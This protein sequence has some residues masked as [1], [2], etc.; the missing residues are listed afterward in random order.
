MKMKFKILDRKNEN[1]SVCYLCKLPLREY[2]SNLPQTYKEFEVQRGIV[3]NKYLDRLAESIAEKKHIPAIVLVSDE[4]NISDDESYLEVRDFDILDGLQRTHRFKV[5]YDSLLL[6][7]STYV[8]GNFTSISKFSRKYSSELKRIDSSSKLLRILEKY[9]P[10]SLADPLDFFDG[11]DIWVEVWTGLEKKDQ[12]KKMLL[13]NAGHKSVNIKHQL[14]LLF[15]GTRLKLEDLLDGDVDIIREKEISS[16]QYSK[17]RKINTYHFSHIISSLVALSAGGLVNTNSDF[18][19]NLQAGE[20]DSVDLIDGFDIA[21]LTEFMRFLSALDHALEN[22]YKEVGVKWIGREVVLVGL[23]G[24]IGNYAKEEG[25]EINTLLNEL[26]GDVVNLSKLLKLK[27]F[28]GARNRVQLNKVN[29]GNV[30]R[31][32][33]FE[34]VHAIITKAPVES[35]SVYFGGSH[36]V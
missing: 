6:L 8:S 2:V 3:S 13:L 34:C 11:N 31:K 26:T 18:V 23:F 24:A 20:V 5:I 15:L 29:I 32:A 14:E 19:S 1:G 12:V 30:N 16:I 4:L 25:C 35:W 17:N 9:N 7:K 21:L 22:E 28:E 36:E 10:A 33:V 27:G